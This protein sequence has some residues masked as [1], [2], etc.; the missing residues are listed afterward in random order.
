MVDRYAFVLDPLVN[1][2]NED[3]EVSSDVS[4][5]NILQQ[6]IQQFDQF[7]VEEEI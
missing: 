7:Q 1:M 2:V 4:R 6:C 5:K 3:I